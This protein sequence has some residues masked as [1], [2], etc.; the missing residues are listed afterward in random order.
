MVPTTF[1]P[2]REGQRFHLSLPMTVRVHKDSI[3]I[4]PGRKPSLWVEAATATATENISSRGCYFPLPRRLP[5]GTHI[6]LEI[7]FPVQGRG[8]SE[9]KL[10]CQG[11][12]IRVDN[13]SNGGQLGIASSIDSYRLAT[14]S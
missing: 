5:T 1:T 7:R 9:V 8:L 13:R 12:V 2:P 14:A 10:C 11:K 6:E 4:H 3:P